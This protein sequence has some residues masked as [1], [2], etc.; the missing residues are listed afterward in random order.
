M[1]LDLVKK[2]HGQKLLFKKNSPHIFFGIGIVGTISSVILAS[3]ATLKM[4]NVLYELQDE[5]ED[6]KLNSDQ[7]KKDIF[8]AY[9]DKAPTLAKA[10]APS[11]IVLTLSIVSLTSS[12]IELN[13]RN[14]ALAAA[15]AVLTKAY[16]D[17]RDR[18]RDKVGSE[19][20]LDIYHG[21]EI[22]GTGKDVTKIV[23]P[24]K[25]SPYARFFDEASKDWVKDPELNRLFVTC[26][27]T[28]LNH[29]LQVRGHV[30]LNEAYDA[31]GIERSS[32]GAIVG[33]VISENSDNYIDFGLYHAQ[34]SRFINGTERSIILDFNVDGVI[35]DKIEKK[36][37]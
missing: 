16:S 36:W 11:A 24:N 12:H 7:V 35:Y 10:Y 25:M 14:K 20:E 5:I 29:I 2:Y 26:Q 17:Y 21:A 28:Y 27:Q 1:K 9:T 19:A 6:I 31:L 3:R 13:K 15:Y 33:W 4:S 8:E 34:S 30:F 22:S 23:D 32:A 18:V 37:R